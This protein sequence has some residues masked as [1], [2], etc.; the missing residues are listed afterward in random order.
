MMTLAVISSSLTLSRAAHG[1]ALGVDQA[2]FGLPLRSNSKEVLER[3][4]GVLGA[5]DQ[6]HRRVRLIQDHR[7][8]LATLSLQKPKPP[9]LLI[10]G[11]KD[12][13]VPFEDFLLLLRNG[14]PSM[15][16][17]PRGPDHGR[18]LSV[19]DD[20]ITASVIIPWVRQRL[21]Q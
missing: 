2:C 13:Q 6:Q 3:H 11:A 18:S 1:L 4:L 10:A 14:S 15:P 21:G 20:E 17:S 7:C 19:K 5:G 9:M 12:T 16:G 8:R